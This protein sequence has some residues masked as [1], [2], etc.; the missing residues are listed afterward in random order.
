MSES[1]KSQVR[2][3]IITGGRE[4]EILLSHQEQYMDEDRHYNRY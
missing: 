1:Y 3:K 2:E 4:A